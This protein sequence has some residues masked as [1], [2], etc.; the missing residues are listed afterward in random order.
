MR[1]NP[2]AVQVDED[3]LG[4]PIVEHAFAIDDFVLLFVE[5]GGVVFEELDEG[6]RLGSFE[7]Y[8]CLAFIDAP[9]TVH[10]HI[11]WFEEIHQ[12]PFRGTKAF[13]INGLQSIRSG[14]EPSAAGPY[15]IGRSGTMIDHCGGGEGAASRSLI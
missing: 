3:V 14:P 8:F 10:G 4:N 12:K 15:S 6:A 11:P 1:R 9:T 13:S 5:G 7:Q 2:H